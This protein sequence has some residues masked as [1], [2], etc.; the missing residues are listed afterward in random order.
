MPAREL[1]V[2]LLR[3]ILT[4]FEGLHD[5]QAD[6]LIHPYHDPVGYPT[7]GYGTLL[8]H[9]RHADLAQ[10]PP[11]TKALADDLM[12]TEAGKVFASVLRLVK[13]PVNDGQVAA[14]V[15]FAYN[16]GAGAL[17]A[18]TLLRMLNRGDYEGAAEQ[19][20]RWNKAGGRILRGLT[21]RRM[22]ERELFLG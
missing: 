15:D 9:E 19:F 20:L 18:S 8:S 16:L 4:R 13:V 1:P 21:L 14:L 7:I 11:I 2:D 6:G 22:A 17:R 5:L 12:M 10:W 3:P